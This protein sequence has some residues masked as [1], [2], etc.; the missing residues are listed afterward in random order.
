MGSR[1]CRGDVAMGLARGVASPGAGCVVGSGRGSPA[2]GRTSGCVG[3]TFARAFLGFA[4]EGGTEIEDGVS[5]P[6][7]IEGRRAPLF[8]R[9]SDVAVSA[10][11]A[12]F[13]GVFGVF[14]VLV[15]AAGAGFLA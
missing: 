15:L 14:G 9:F 11:F 8:V 13:A 3:A 5:S 10:L 12:G 2:T 6:R 4:E 1:A 7:E